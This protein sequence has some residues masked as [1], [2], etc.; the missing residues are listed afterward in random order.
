MKEPA[1]AAAVRLP[2]LHR[3]L[4]QGPLGSYHDVY[5]DLDR[6]SALAFLD[7]A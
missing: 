2:G 1:Y 4:F 7:T 6:S 3:A 5:G